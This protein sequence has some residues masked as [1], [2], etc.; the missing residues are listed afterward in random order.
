MILV[1]DYDRYRATVVPGLIELIGGA[2]PTPWFEDVCR[3]LGQH[4]EGE[5]RDLVAELRKRPVRDLGPDRRLGAGPLLV[6]RLPG[7]AA[8]PV[9]RAGRPARRRDAVLALRG[10][11]PRDAA[12]P[13]HR[14]R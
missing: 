13:G 11:R 14:S 9:A 6:G 7:G 12:A 10:G 1:F 5:W 4:F 2:G 8:L 3:R